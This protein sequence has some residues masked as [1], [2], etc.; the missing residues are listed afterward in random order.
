MIVWLIFCDFCWLNFLNFFR[1]STA[2][3]CLVVFIDVNSLTQSSLKTMNFYS[4]LKWFVVLFWN[5]LIHFKVFCYFLFQKFFLKST[6]EFSI[7]RHGL[8]TTDKIHK[9][10]IINEWAKEFLCKPHEELGRKRVVC[11]Y[12]PTATKKQTVLYKTISL[13]FLPGIE[14]KKQYL[15]ELMLHYL[16]VF[17]ITELWMEYFETLKHLFSYFTIC[18]KK[19]PL[20]SSKVRA[21]IRYSWNHDYSSLW[22]KWQILIVSFAMDRSTTWTEM[23]FCCSRMYVGWIP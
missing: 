19:K 1:G 6:S 3:F 13:A 22:F 9:L 4:F 11:P 21:S 14:K 18:L 8:L 5:L 20:L 7:I 2:K 15:K 10:Q 17:L 16:K 12:M 23:I